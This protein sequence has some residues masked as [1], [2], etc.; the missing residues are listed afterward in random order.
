MAI[1]NKDG[2][3]LKIDKIF[4]D[5][6][7]KHIALCNV[8]KNEEVRKSSTSFDNIRQDRI[9]IPNFDNYI[10]DNNKSMRDN[11]LSIG[12]LVIKQPIY[13]DVNASPQININKFSDW[14]DC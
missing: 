10:L 12:Y 7:G 4:Y 5:E 14:T 13:E 6:K 1:K 9:S 8:Y 3:Y 2:N 11:L